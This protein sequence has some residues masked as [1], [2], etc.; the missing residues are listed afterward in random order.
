[1]KAISEFVREP[2]K[3][4]H[5]ITYSFQEIGIELEK[6]F[7]TKEVWSLFYRKKYTE[8]LIRQAFIDYQKCNVKNFKY[9]MGILNNKL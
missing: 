6:E 3:A 1:M 9:F 8:Q 5:K 7:K 2:V 4:K